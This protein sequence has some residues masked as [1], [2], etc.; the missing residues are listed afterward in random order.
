MDNAGVSTQSA[1]TPV[2]QTLLFIS[3]VFIPPCS[4]RCT[5]SSN[6]YTERSKTERRRKSPVLALL[7]GAHTDIWLE[8][9]DLG[10]LCCCVLARCLGKETKMLFPCCGIMFLMLE[11]T[12]NNFLH[13]CSRNSATWQW[14]LAPLQNTEFWLEFCHGWPLV[15]FMISIT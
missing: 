3:S 1:T 9:E 14:H 5:F 12:F 13:L 11:R 8:R 7:A 10:M 6:A 4:T 2:Y 15:I